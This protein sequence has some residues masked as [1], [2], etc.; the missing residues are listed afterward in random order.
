[1][2]PCQLVGPFLLT[3][4]DLT[5]HAGDHHLKFSSHCDFHCSIILLFA[6][7]HSACFNKEHVS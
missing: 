1:M 6:A 7:V 5:M 4:C 2:L 3:V